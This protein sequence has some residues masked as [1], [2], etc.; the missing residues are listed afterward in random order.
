MPSPFPGMDPFLENPRIFTDFHD[1]FITYLREQLQQQ[2][3]APYYAPIGERAWIEVSH[4]FIEPDVNV[5]RPAAAPSSQGGVAVAEAAAPRALPL[6]V[7]VPHD[8]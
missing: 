5:V 3:P 6:V 7:T 4:R 8:E 2:L 1:S